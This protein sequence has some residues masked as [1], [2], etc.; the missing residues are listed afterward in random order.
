MIYGDIRVNGDVVGRWD[1]QRVQTR[2]SGRHTYRWQ[3]WQR[4]K[5]VTGDLDHTYDDGAVILTAK[6]LTAA[7]ALLTRPQPSPGATQAPD[8]TQSAPEIQGSQTGHTGPAKGIPGPRAHDLPPR[9]DGRA[10]IWD[11]WHEDPPVF[12]CPPP[13]ELDCCHHCGSL[14][15]RRVSIGK[16]AESTLT[17]H[18]RLEHGQ[19]HARRLT[20]W[21]CRDCH[22]DTILDS[23]GTLW[24][25]DDTDY[26]KDGSWPK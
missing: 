21:R 12:V 24:D 15:P 4:G 2:R 13:P 18:S 8:P 10:A 9:W 1:A 7:G 23:A 25:L 22:H 26:G 17:T 20:A 3:A 6:V 11:T 16:V 5:Y 14:E 19:G